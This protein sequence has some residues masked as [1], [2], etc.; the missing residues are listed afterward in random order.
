[1]KQRINIV[2]DL[3]TASLQSDAAILSIAAVP[4]NPD[5]LKRNDLGLQES[6]FDVF[7]NGETGE[8]L[9]P[10]YEVINATSCFLQ[11]M[12]FDMETARFWAK[13]DE[14]AKAELLSRPGLTIG[15]AMNAF[16]NYLEGIKQAYDAD[17]VL[18]A[19]GSD[20]DFPILANAY[21][22]VL[23]GVK[24]P[25]DYRNKRDARSIV[26]DILEARFGVEEKPYNRIPEITHNF[27][28]VKHSAICDAHRTAWSVAYAKSLCP[29][30]SGAST[31]STTPKSSE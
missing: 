5:G 9:A 16:H 29:S 31:S 8:P 23:K 14:E 30:I 27:K 7:P 3:E 25:W 17:I 28:F 11:G 6:I 13:Q 22:K 26:L 2:V 20:F 15:Q 4:F 19:Q 1:M 18:W 12:H 10:F 21:A 24:M